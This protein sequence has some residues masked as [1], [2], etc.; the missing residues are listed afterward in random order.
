M[1]VVRWHPQD[2]DPSELPAGQMLLVDSDAGDN[3]HAI[4]DVER[5]CAA[6]GL[7]RVKELHLAVTRSEDGAALRRARCYR[8]YPEE[9]RSEGDEADAHARR[10]RAQPVTVSSVELLQER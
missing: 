3:A 2:V 6:R 9:L 5:W 10:V 7:R 1:A 4:L 8:P